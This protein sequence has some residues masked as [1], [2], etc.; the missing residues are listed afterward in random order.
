M[1]DRHTRLFQARWEF[2]DGRRWL[3][4]PGRRREIIT[5]R[6]VTARAIV[7]ISRAREWR[8]AAI[9]LEPWDGAAEVCVVCPRSWRR[10]RDTVSAA[11]LTAPSRYRWCRHTAVSQLPS[12]RSKGPYVSGQA[13]VTGQPPFCGQTGCLRLT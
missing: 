9:R 11:D 5:A 3:A 6:T 12:R 10:Y 2:S 1:I 13:P 8:A 7:D 4:G